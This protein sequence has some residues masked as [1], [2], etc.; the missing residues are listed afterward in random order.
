MS[1]FLKRK[2][3]VL[4]VL[5]LVAVS[6]VLV[7]LSSIYYFTPSGKLALP[8]IVKNNKDSAVIAPS[9]PDTGALARLLA[10]V[11]SL[12]NSP[13]LAHGG[14]GFFLADADSG[15]VL[16]EFNSKRTLVPASI[17]KTVTTGTALSILGPGYRYTTLLQH[18][19]K[20]EGKVLKGNIYIRGSGDP[21]LG[22]EV[23]GS[24]RVEN[25][26]S[27]WVEVIRNLG[28]DSIDG[29]I[30]GDA[31]IFENDLIPAGWAWEDMQSDY[32]APVCG[33][34]FHENTYDLELTCSGNNVN[35]KVR[36]EV[37][38]LKLFN[39]VKVNK[40]VDKSY[41]YV[42]GAPYMNERVLL[43]EANGTFEEKSSVPD[44]A[45]FCAYTLYRS[46]RKNGISVKD[47]CT[48]TRKLKQ[49]GK[50]EKNERKTI[51]TTPSPSLA[52]LVAH[53]NAVSQNFYA[54]TLLKTIAANQTGYGS[55]TGGVNAVIDFWKSKGIDLKGFY[56]VDGSGV[57][58]FDAITPKQLTEMLIA[59]SKDE[60]MFPAFFSSLPVAGY[61]S[62][63][64]ICAGTAAQDHVHF[65]SGYMT[66]VRCFT[67]YVKLNSGRT[68]AFTMMA[69]NYLYGV[70]EMRNKLEHLMVL[71]AELDSQ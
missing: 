44:P 69:N 33:L 39:Q 19:G 6:I 10:A 14:F 53:T 28:I 38:G 34:S 21:S 31:D 35:C 45:L 18:D 61:G 5:A 36:P 65:K 56:M 12:G 64:N 4:Q 2:L 7:L 51:H 24:T 47:S 22:S 29:A 8:A 13:G 23:F 41:A 62:T 26:V 59:Y 17:L 48:T 11:D 70:Q 30:I 42:M 16:C 1:S 52:D 32:C 60:K 15:K 55:T 3:T 68:L 57:S 46:L 43:G 49:L 71:M 9:V 27:K 66:R 25:V 54:E 58:R 37:P 50:Y 63:E 40:A 67:G 20:T